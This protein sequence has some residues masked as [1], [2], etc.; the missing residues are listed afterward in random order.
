MANKPNVFGYEVHHNITANP[1]T[2]KPELRNS[3]LTKFDIT[4]NLVEFPYNSEMDIFNT[5]EIIKS[6]YNN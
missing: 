5:E 4:G 1:Y 6:L 3:Y 2:S